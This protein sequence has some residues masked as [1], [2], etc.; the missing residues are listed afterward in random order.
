[1]SAHTSFFPSFVCFSWTGVIICLHSD[2]LFSIFVIYTLKK[3]H[4]SCPRFHP[5]SL[6]FQTNLPAEIQYH[7]M[8]FLP[9]KFTLGLW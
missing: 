3:S 5:P 7:T 9:L 8:I 6:L 4:L 1:V 2:C